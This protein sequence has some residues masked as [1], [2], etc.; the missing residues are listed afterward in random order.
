MV[1][2]EDT[3]VAELDGTDTDIAEQEDT[4]AEQDGTHT[5]TAEHEDT[6]AAELNGTHTDITLEGTLDFVYQLPTSSGRMPHLM[7]FSTC[8]KALFMNSASGNNLC[9]N[10]P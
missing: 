10:M 6:V 1:E 4:A 8:C 2:H 9:T 7:K 3:V 5:D